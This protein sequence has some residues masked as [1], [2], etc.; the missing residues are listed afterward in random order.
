MCACVRACVR[1]CVH[2]CLW[3]GVDAWLRGC[4]RALHVCVRPC[5]PRLLD[6]QG[7]RAGKDKP[8]RLI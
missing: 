2:N 3:A 4:V 1:A 8:F 6:E 5:V 7:G